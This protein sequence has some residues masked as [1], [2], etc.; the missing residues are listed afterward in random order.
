[1]DSTF[2]KETVIKDP[3]D[4]LKLSIDENILVRLGN[5][6]R[7]VGKLHAFDLHLNMVLGDVEET[8]TDIDIDDET[9]EEFFSERKRIIPMLFVRGDRIILISPPKRE[10]VN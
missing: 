10:E 8:V 7:L 1:M 6:R 2:I 5:G 3:F 9:Y 4:L